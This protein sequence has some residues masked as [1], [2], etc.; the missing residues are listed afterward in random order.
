MQFKTN[1]KKYKKQLEY[2]RWKCDAEK[3]LQYLKS[4]ASH[5]FISTIQDELMNPNL[6]PITKNTLIHDPQG[7]ENKRKKNL[8]LKISALK[9]KKQLNEE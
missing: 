5:Q 2:Q 9:K 6:I 7:S 3:F 4:D 1:N 8:P